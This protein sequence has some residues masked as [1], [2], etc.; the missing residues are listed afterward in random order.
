ML[1]DLLR[2][3]VPIDDLGYEEFCESYAAPVNPK[4][5]NIQVEEADVRRRAELIPGLLERLDRHGGF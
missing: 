1:F 2:Q 5:D 3:A 4:S